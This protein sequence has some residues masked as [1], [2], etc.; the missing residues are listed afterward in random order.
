MKLKGFI[1]LYR[2][3]LLW[4]KDLSDRAYRMYLFLRQV[5]DWDKKHTRTVGT[6]TTTIKEIRKHLPWSNGK[7]SNVLKELLNKGYIS[8]GT[9]N[10]IVVTNFKILNLKFKEA[11]QILQSSER[12]VLNDE[13]PIQ[14]TENLN[15]EAQSPDVY[16]TPEHIGEIATNL[17][18][19]RIP[20]KQ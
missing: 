4:A 19:W 15:P 14:K 5:V 20:K 18:P 2:K 6:V 10:E 7:T 9:D 12:N 3:E 1:R 11:E 16:K 17:Y 8:R 13:R